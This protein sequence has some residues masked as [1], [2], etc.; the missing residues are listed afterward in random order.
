MTARPWEDR[1]EIVKELYSDLNVIRGSGGEWPWGQP[2]WWQRGFGMV[3]VTMV[4]SDAFSPAGSTVTCGNVLYLL[5]FG[6]W[7]SFIYVL[8]AAMM[9]ITIVGAPYGECQIWDPHV[10]GWVSHGA[11]G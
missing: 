5:L 6:W 2:M 9:F 10:K 7:L 1:S 4:P 3:Q 11:P 8:M